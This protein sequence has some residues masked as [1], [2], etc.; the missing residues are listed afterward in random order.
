MSADDFTS[1]CRHFGQRYW[2]RLSSYT[3]LQPHSVRGLPLPPFM[4]AQR[5]HC[6]VCDAF[7]VS[8]HFACCPLGPGCFVCRVFP[9]QELAIFWSK[10]PEEDAVQ[11]GM[12]YIIV[13]KF[14][15]IKMECVCDQNAIDYCDLGFVR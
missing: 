8:V 9:L 11:C 3:F 7:V 5:L 12:L 10:R 1:Q 15:H 6:R 13:V 14:E 2:Q 4:S